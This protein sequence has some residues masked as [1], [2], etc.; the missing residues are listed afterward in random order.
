MKEKGPLRVVGTMSGTSLD[1]VDA[2]EIVTDGVTVSEFGKTAY[3]PY[4]ADEREVLRSALGL[5]PEEAGVREAAEIVTDAHRALLAAFPE[6]ELV[7]FHGQTLAHDPEGRGTHQAGDGAQLA[8]DL[9]KPVLWDFRSADVAA[10]GQGRRSRPLII[11]PWPGG[12]GRGH[13]LLF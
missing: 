13:R 2:A 6:A 10:G 11:L 3:R 9:G 8:K 12:W 1:G 5:W 4:S 7:G